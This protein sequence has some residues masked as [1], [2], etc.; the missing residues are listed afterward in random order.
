ARS[1]AIKTAIGKYN[2][3]AEAMMPPKPVLDWEQV[4]EYAFLADFDL[5]RESREDI[6]QEPWALPSGRTAMDQHFKIICAEEEIQQ[7]NVEIR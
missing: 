6:R 1:K 7:L 5:L 2:A 4:V 3:A